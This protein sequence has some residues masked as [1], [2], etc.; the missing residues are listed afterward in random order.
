M[1]RFTPRKPVSKWSSTNKER[2]RR[3]IKAGQMSSA[4]NRAIELARK[5]GAWENPVSPQTST[6]MPPELGKELK[7]NRK[8]AEFFEELAPS[9][10]RQYVVWIASAK[11][12]E[13]KT[14]RL[15]E[16]MAL[17]SRG[18]KLGMR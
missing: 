16:T 7:K 18:E 9:Y 3:M 14:R 17:L 12:P 15:N 5:N 13:T 1:H 6:A 4:G 8:A 11:R 2:A 10:Q